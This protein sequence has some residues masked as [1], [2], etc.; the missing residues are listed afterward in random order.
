MHAQIHVWNKNNFIPTNIT[1]H[2]VFC[3]MSW[4]STNLTTSIWSII[5]LSKSDQCTHSC[6]FHL[7][8]KYLK[9]SVRFQGWSGWNLIPIA[10][11]KLFESDELR[12]LALNTFISW[13]LSIYSIVNHDKSEL[14]FNLAKIRLWHSSKAECSSSSLT[15]TTFL[16]RKI[17]NM[18]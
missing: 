13:L 16:P 4:L 17:V 6:T 10:T 12:K 7:V 14:S 8:I 11:R 3:T 2:D 9:T 5:Y 1:L 15:H 18:S